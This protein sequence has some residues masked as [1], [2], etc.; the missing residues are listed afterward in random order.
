[1]DRAQR[2]AA[3][4]FIRPSLLVDVRVDLDRLA[5]MLSGPPG[6]DAIKTVL[7][8]DADAEP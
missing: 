8:L 1:M 2:S 7:S 6:H 4:G 5:D 3:L